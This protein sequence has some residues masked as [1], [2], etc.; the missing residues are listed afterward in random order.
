MLSCLAW[1]LDPTPAESPHLTHNTAYKRQR[2]LRKSSRSVSTDLLCTE[3]ILSDPPEFASIHHSPRSH[4]IAMMADST[5]VKLFR[6]RDLPSEVEPSILLTEIEFWFLATLDTQKDI[7]RHPLRVH[8]A[9]ARA[10]YRSRSL[11]P[12]DRYTRE[13]W[14]WDGHT[15]YIEGNI[16]RSLRC[17][18]QDESL[19]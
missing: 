2:R 6:F 12:Y 3:N 18:G 10:W 14:R 17:H 15:P 7:S 1:N 5:S 13:T 4:W 16:P 19:R 11:I 8:P 9:N